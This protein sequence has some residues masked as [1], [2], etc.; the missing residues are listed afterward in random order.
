MGDEVKLYH[1]DWTP[2]PKRLALDPMMASSRRATKY[3]AAA[4]YKVGTRDYA[5]CVQEH[6]LFPFSGNAPL[7]TCL[8]SGCSDGICFAK[9]TRKWRVSFA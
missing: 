9:L 8:F 4:A 6:E 7:A 5:T 2:G 3:Y 1:F